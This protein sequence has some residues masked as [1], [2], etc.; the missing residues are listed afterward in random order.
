MGLLLARSTATGPTRNLFFDG[1]ETRNVSPSLAI[2]NIGVPTTGA[3]PITRISAGRAASRNA[4]T[5]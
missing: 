1:I 5:S 2:S 3:C 4:L